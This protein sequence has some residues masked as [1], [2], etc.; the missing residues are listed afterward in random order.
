MSLKI[1]L[2]KIIKLTLH[3]YLNTKILL[4]FVYPVSFLFFYWSI[5]I[6]WII[7]IAT[8]AKCKKSKN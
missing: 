1:R 2:V 3:F 4:D 7:F 6:K 8:T 5:S